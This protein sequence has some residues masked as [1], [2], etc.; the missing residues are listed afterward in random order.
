VPDQPASNDEVVLE[1][2]QSALE[3][4]RVARRCLLKPP[5]PRALFFHAQQAA[6]KALKAYLLALGSSGFPRTHLL[7]DL[8]KRVRETDGIEPRAECVEF[9]DAYSV[10]VRYPDTFTPP[11]EVAE[12]AIGH[13]VEVIEHVLSQLGLPPPGDDS[14]QSKLTW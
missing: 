4:V 7:R 12:A 9:L 2:V 8:V 3:D 11:L 14:E 5:A 13:A 1:W 6:E 10:G